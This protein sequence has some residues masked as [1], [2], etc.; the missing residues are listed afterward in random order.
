MS[1]GR[2]F[3]HGDVVQVQKEM[4]SV[5]SHFDADFE[6]V[7]EEHT[8]NGHGGHSYSLLKENGAGVAWYNE[9]LLTKTKRISPEQVVELKLKFEL[10]LKV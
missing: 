3:F 1:D 10:S 6:G 9:N 2:K 5:M 7:V 4:P 8:G